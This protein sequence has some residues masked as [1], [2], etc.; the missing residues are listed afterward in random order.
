MKTLTWNEARTLRGA[1]MRAGSVSGIYLIGARYEKFGIP[2]SYEWVYVGRSNSLSRRLIEH[3]PINE[4]NPLLR[5]WIRD[6]G[7][8][9]IVRFAIV[10]ESDTSK[11]EMVLVRT[12]APKHNRIMFKTE[13]E[14][15]YYIKYA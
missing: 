4:A 1:A 6:I 2:M 13:K 3:L 15:E 9:L 8:E 5:S 12:L 11:T 10:P 7:D 14:N